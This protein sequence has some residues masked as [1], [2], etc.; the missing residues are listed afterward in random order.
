MRSLIAVGQTLTP[1]AKSAL[2]KASATPSN[3][4]ETPSRHSAGL[5]PLVDGLR[6]NASSITL[7]RDS[8]TWEV[9]DEHNASLVEEEKPA[10]ASEA[11]DDAASSNGTAGSKASVA[12]WKTAANGAALNEFASSELFRLLPK[13]ATVC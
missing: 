3:G 5:T 8:D 1:S 12:S 11:T 2:N 9:L 13:H 10:A 7:P 4:L 6:I